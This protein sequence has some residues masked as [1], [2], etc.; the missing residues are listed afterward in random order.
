VLMVFAGTF[1]RKVNVTNLLIASF[2]TVLIH[3]LV[4]DIGAIFY[5]GSMY[6]KTFAGY[7]SALVGAIPFE[8]NLLVSNLLF[9]ALMFGG[10]EYAKNKFPALEFNKQTALQHS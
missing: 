9:S 2:A 5:E 10:F 1:I 6:P 3:W 4:S 8:R 7:L